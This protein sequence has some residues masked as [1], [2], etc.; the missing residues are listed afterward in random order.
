MEYKIIDIYGAEYIYKCDSKE[1]ARECFD[2]ENGK[3]N[4]ESFLENENKD[5]I[6]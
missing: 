5:Y 4:F 6:N 3:D 1:E 2:A